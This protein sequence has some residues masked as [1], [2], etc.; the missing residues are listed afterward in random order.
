MI[1]LIDTGYS[2]TH[3]VLGPPDVV[4]H[5][6]LMANFIKDYS[7]EARIT[8]IQI[9]EQ[10]TTY[11]VVKMF[12]RLS[13]QVYASD[14]VVIPWVVAGNDDI[15]SAVK[16]L[17]RY[18]KVICAA[19]ND[20]MDIANFSPAR[21]NNVTVVGCLNKSGT[22]AK[23]SNWSKTE[24]EWMYGTNIQQTGI[25][26]VVNCIGT[27]VSTAIYAGLWHRACGTRNASVFMRRATAIL[28]RKLKDELR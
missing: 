5:G 21:V 9:F 4:G 1:Y 27:S 24:M 17:T 23:L 6:T 19:G 3:D 10:S 12:E 11:L 13:K 14:I 26:G 18:C 28:G 2:G 20:D 22:K 8:V 16:R 25:S 15:D 7:P